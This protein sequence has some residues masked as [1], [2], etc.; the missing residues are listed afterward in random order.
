MQ[1]TTGTGSA[2]GAIGGATGLQDADGIAAA[3]A[4]GASFAG[5]PVLGA[6]G[7]GAGLATGI[8]AKKIAQAPMTRKLVGE[9]VTLTEKAILAGPRTPS[10]VRRLRL[11]KAALIELAEALPEEKNNGN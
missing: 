7:L 8:F 10:I 11:D 4:A 5:F 3:G 9:L 6:L 2:V 1:E